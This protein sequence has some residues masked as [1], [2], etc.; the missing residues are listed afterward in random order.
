MA[1]GY[2]QETQVS[3][4]VVLGERI[5]HGRRTGR[6]FTVAASTAGSTC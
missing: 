3:A 6:Y 5:E 4:R 1:D 2:R